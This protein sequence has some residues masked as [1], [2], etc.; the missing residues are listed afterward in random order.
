MPIEII[1]PSSVH[2]PRGYSH[3]ARVGN[4]LYLAGQVALDPDGNLVGKGDLEAQIRQVVSNLKNILAE[5][6]GGLEHIVKSTS[7]L[8]EVSGV[9]TFRSLRLELFPDP[10]PPNT[11]LIIKSLASPDFLVEIEAIAVLD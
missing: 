4:T 5:M 9:G 1:N 11:L 3:V 10:P 7:I 6:G 2:K 8:T